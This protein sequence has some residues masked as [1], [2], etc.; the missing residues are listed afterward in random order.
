M[1]SLVLLDGGIQSTFLAVEAAKES[2]TLLL[3]ID[4]GQESLEG[5]WDAASATANFCNSKLMSVRTEGF[6]PL[7]G[8]FKVLCLVLHAMPVARKERCRVIY[9]GLDKD[10]I[11]MYT[12]PNTSE[13]FIE[14]LCSLLN[15]AYPKYD[16]RGIWLGDIRVEMP[17]RMLHLG[18]IIRLGNEWEIP[19]VET[20]SCIRQSKLHCGV[21]AGCVKRKEAFTKEG[22]VDPTTYRN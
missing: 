19:W 3:F 7:E 21:C 15:L 2:E 20:R 11:P 10:D 4:H 13:E 18:Q 5:E 6:P 9:H 1:R 17:L 16:K 14:H 12:D 8:L 22:S